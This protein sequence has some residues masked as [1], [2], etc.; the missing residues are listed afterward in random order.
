MILN[1]EAAFAKEVVLGMMLGREKALATAITY[2]P[3]ASNSSAQHGS[4]FRIKSIYQIAELIDFAEFLMTEL[5]STNRKAVYAFSD[6]MVDILKV[7]GAATPP[8]TGSSSDLLRFFTRLGW[9]TLK[10]RAQEYELLP[11]EETT[12]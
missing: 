2:V 8:L 7:M 9:N 4:D 12:S 5:L 6:N 10:M 3:H 1:Q 11:L